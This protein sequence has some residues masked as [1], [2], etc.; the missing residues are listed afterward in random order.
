MKIQGDD[1][2][3]Q[4]QQMMREV[5]SANG[6][7]HLQSTGQLQ[8]DRVSA[9]DKVEFSSLLKN[10]IDTVNGLQADSKNKA[11]AFEM[12][13]RSVSI[14]DVM[15]AQQKSSVAFEATV[16]VRNKMVD[17]YKEIMSMTV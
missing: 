12:G 1:L 8:P 10:A 11:T 14:G 15:I 7:E 6:L 2:I 17:A 4:M 3:N 13:D 16:Q 9:D 5:R